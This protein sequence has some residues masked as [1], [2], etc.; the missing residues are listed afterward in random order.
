MKQPRE[1]GGAR[2]S[3]FAKGL[4][5]LAAVIEHDGVRADELAERLDLPLSSVYRYLRTL[6]AHGFTE[7]SEGGASIPG[8][9]LEGHGAEL[10]TRRL[11]TLAQPCVVE[12]AAATGETVVLTVRRGLRAICLAEVESI[13]PIRLMFRAG[14]LLPLHAG[15]GQRVLLAFAPEAVIRAVLD[16]ELTAY[17]R[18]TPT[19]AE[20]H[21]T[22]P[23]VR[24]YLLAVSRSEYTDGAFAMAVPVFR[25]SQLVC[26]ITVAGPVKR[27]TPEWQLTTRRHLEAAARSLSE[28]L[29]APP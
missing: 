9:R 4:N 5:V 13:H 25:N 8:P 19:R 29:A 28:L 16:G 21:R 10:S 7:E 2:E 6:R 20:L 18:N 15:A 22:L 27:C 1:A 17:T 3:S 11:S 26:S 14:Q 24:K 23:K 12:L